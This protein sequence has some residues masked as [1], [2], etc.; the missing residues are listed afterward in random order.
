MRGCSLV[1]CRHSNVAIDACIAGV[2]VECDDGA[3]FALYRNGPQ[4]DE[5]ARREFLGR[6]AWWNWGGTRPPRR[7]DSWRR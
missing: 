1:V 6:L 4:P 5:N 3:A 2:P 7:G